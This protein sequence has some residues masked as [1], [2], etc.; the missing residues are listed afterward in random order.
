MSTFKD[1]EANVISTNE[2]NLPEYSLP[3]I[4]KFGSYSY[5]IEDSQKNVA[6]RIPISFGYTFPTEYYLLF[7]TIQH[8]SIVSTIMHKILTRKPDGFELYLQSSGA[9]NHGIYWLAIFN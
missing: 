4:V 5:Q 2:L 9:G 3:S 8:N 7:Y 6:L 1:I